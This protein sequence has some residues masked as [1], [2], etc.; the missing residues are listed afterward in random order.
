V[1]ES[2]AR[3]RAWLRSLRVSRGCVVA[4]FFLAVATPSSALAASAGV[5][6]SAACHGSASVLGVT[7]FAWAVTLSSAVSAWGR[8]LEWRAR[9]SAG[10]FAAGVTFIAALALLSALAW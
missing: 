5:A 10:I 1:I 9:R 2:E 8:L 7:L 4:A 3:L 6:A